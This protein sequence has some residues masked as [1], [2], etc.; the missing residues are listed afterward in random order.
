MYMGE[1]MVTTSAHSLGVAPAALPVRIWALPIGV[2]TLP[3]APAIRAGA[4]AACRLRGGLHRDQAVGYPSAVLVSAVP[5][6]VVGVQISVVVPVRVAFRFH[7]QIEGED[8]RT[9]F[10]GSGCA[11][12][13]RS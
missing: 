2:C 7:H 6:I 8:G 3:V 11:T 1:R 10:R 5:H 9:Y 13:T 12:G 4:V